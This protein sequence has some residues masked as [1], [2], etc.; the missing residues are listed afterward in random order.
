[1]SEAKALCGTFFI[2]LSLPTFFLTKSMWQKGYQV[3]TETCPSVTMT[4]KQALESAESPGTASHQNS[5]ETLQHHTSK[6]KTSSNHDDLW[7]EN[8]PEPQHYN[9]FC[10]FLSPSCVQVREGQRSRQVSC[11]SVIQTLVTSANLTWGP[12]STQFCITLS[13]SKLVRCWSWFLCTF[14]VLQKTLRI[15]AVVLWEGMFF[16][17]QQVTRRRLG[18]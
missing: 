5:R 10:K 2:G 11:A 13:N 7:G 8:K 12:L 3:P 18:V 9:H 4:T 1:M 14:C 17:S 15:R 16:G 6:I